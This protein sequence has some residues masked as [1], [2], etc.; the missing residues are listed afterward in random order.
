MKRIAIIVGVL[1]L[2]A[3]LL[4][5]AGKTVSYETEIAYE[6][7][8]KVVIAVDFRMGELDISRGRGDYLARVVGE[9]D[10]EKFEVKIEYEEKGSTGYFSFE[11]KKKKSFQI[12][13]DDR[14]NE[15]KWTLLLGDKLP[16]NINIDAGMASNTF[17]FSGLKIEGLNMDVGM[18]S[19]NILF[20]KPNPLVMTDFI[21]DA[22]M[23][24]TEIYGLGNAN[25]RHLTI[26][27]GMS[28]T[29]LDF[30]GELAYD[31]E[32]KIDAGMGS[33]NIILPRNVGLKIKAPSDFTS[34]LSIPDNLKEVRE[35][36]YKSQDYEQA[37]SNLY[38]DIDFGMGSVNVEYAE[39]L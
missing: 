12:F 1:L 7:A 26:D 32:V 14:E 19:N 11:F 4:M 15:N 10:E 16:M 24:S 3:S 28:S 6:D 25:F 27:E 31:A 2:S 8:D 17:D 23:S 22:G 36:I 39:S 5:G 21:I 35:N 18:S 9:Y 33:T 13:S 34:S 37:K 29:I 20:R 30:S 38:F